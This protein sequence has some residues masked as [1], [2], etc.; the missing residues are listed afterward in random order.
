MNQDISVDRYKKQMV[1][2]I[3][4]KEFHSVNYMIALYVQC[5]KKNSL[6]F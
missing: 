4:G 3:N 5:Y 2:K 1:K 6:T